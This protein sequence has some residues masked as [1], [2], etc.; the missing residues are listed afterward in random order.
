MQPQIGCSLQNRTRAG[1]KSAV[2]MLRGIIVQRDD[3]SVAHDMS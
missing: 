2:I 1:D 3:T